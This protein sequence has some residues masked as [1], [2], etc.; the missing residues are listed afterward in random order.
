M[1]SIRV[2]G[3][4]AFLRRPA[5]DAKTE[6]HAW[7]CTGGRRLG[8][9]ESG[10]FTGFRPALIISKTTNHSDGWQ[11]WD[12]KRDPHNLMHHRLHPEAS[13][14]ESTSVNS[15][16]SQLDFY[17]NGFK[18]RGSSNDTNGS[19]DTYIYLAFAESPFKYSRAR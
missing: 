10:L 12:N 11:I 5:G 8:G 14:V 16:S 7:T 19:G 4:P 1:W 9:R 2:V 6:H 15:A 18:W 3:N 13:Q 17:S